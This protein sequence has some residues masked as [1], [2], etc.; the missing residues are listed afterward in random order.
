M[1]KIKIKRI[2]KSLPLPSFEKDAACFDLPCRETV[3]IK[4][5]E[6]ALVPVNCVMIIPKNSALM[7]FSRSSTPLRKG[8]ILANSVGIVDP[9]Y[10]GDNDEIVAQF[11]NITKKTVEV[12]KGE[13]LVQGMIVKREEISWVEVNK[14]TGKG[15]GGYD[16]VLKRYNKKK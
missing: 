13:H 6:I 14:M 2:D 4:P 16:K 7:V 1:M 5:G 8:L 3:K 11:L 15:R 9:F 12:K 10:R